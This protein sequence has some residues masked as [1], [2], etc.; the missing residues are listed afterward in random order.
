VIADFQ[1]TENAGRISFRRR[2]TAACW[3]HPRIVIGVPSEIYTGGKRAVQEL[4][5]S[6]AG[7]RGLSRWQPWRQPSA[8]AC[9]RRAV[10]KHGGLIRRRHH[11][12]AVISM[13]GIVY[14]RSVPVAGNEMD[15]AV[16]SVSGSQIQP[17][18]W[19]RTAEQAK[20]EI[21]RAYP[22]E[23]AADDGSKRPQPD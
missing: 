17:I 6:R 7:Q 15:E 9:H 5:L 16:M 3:F 10:R 11:D 22:L 23:K 1:V 13:S 8:P 18:G 19:E 12:I 21:A 20:M 4:R 14:S 2:T